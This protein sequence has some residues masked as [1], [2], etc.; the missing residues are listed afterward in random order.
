MLR[1][2]SLISF[3]T[4]TILVYHT[5][6]LLTARE[7]YPGLADCHERVSRVQLG[8]TAIGTAKTSYD[9]KSLHT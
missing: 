5:G 8:R 3:A 9:A 4:V 7:R 6:Q 2:I 1:T